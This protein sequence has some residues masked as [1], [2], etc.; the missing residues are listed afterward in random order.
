[1]ITDEKKRCHFTHFYFYK[2]FC[3]T[4]EFASRRDEHI[5]PACDFPRLSR[6]KTFLSGSIKTHKFGSK[7]DLEGK[8]TGS[9]ISLFLDREN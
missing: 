9:G 5:L 2:A 6:K 1:M 8:K 3:N 4:T 7:K